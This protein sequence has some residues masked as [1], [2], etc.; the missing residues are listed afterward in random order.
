MG[1]H[2]TARERNMILQQ[3]GAW[4]HGNSNAKRSA[5]A[6]VQGHN[7]FR[8]HISYEWRACSPGRQAL[9]GV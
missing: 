6:V 2:G 8:A 9:F 7:V 5:R 1:L 3:M 4:K